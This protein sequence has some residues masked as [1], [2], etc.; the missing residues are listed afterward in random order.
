MLVALG[1]IQQL[2]MYN[3]IEEYW[4]DYLVE[5]E[6]RINA[7]ID[8]Q[9]ELELKKKKKSLYLKTEVCK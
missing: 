5:F 7:A 4:Q 2:G 9:E 6:S 8:E 3:F 1:P